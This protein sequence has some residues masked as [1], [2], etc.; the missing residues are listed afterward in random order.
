MTVNSGATLAFVY[1]NAFG[2]VGS[3][4]N[5]TVVVDGGTVV[6]SNGTEGAVN[7][8]RDL[9]LRNGATLEATKDSGVF[10]TYQLTGTVTVDGTSPSFISSGVGNGGVAVGNGINDEGITTF[11]V[12]DVTS[13]SA[14][15]LT[16]SAVIGNSDAS[17]QDIGGL[18][19]SGAGSLFLTAA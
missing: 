19:K 7:V 14:A 12:A 4:P 18:T 1:R 2:V 6:T 13:S 3:T 16:I 9:T 5:T 15:D 8:L 17:G 11:N 10:K